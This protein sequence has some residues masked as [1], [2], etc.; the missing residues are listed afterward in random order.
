MQIFCSH[1]E[2]ESLWYEVFSVGEGGRGQWSIVLFARVR[3]CGSP[4]S[5]LIK[6]PRTPLLYIKICSPTRYWGHFAI[7][8]EGDEVWV[9]ISLTAWLYLFILP[10]RE[11]T[12]LMLSIGQCLLRPTSRRNRQ[13]HVCLIFICFVIS[14]SRIFRCKRDNYA[15]LCTAHSI[16]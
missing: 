11:T 8:L 13:Y 6:L 12:S 7:V 14:F 4:V 5:L 1:V 10:T 2:E 3:H 15:S 16:C 9:V